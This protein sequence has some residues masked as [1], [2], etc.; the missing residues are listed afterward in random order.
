[1]FHVTSI[2]SLL[3]LATPVSVQAINL[4][5]VERVTA[6]HLTQLDRGGAGAAPKQAPAQKGNRQGSP[7]KRSGPAARQSRSGSDGASVRQRSGGEGVTVRRRG[8]QVGGSSRAYRR[9]DRGGR[10][11]VR[12]Y[13]GPG[14]EF[15]FYDGYYHGDCAWLRR[16]ARATGS[17]YWWTRYR[18]CRAL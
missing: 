18:Q 8:D 5:N 1:M 4:N 16:K 12:F 17:Q 6:V 3:L 2:A 15:Y 7:A 13:W 14:A 11:G 9:A 10:R